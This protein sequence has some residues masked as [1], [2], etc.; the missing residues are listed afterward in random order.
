V[1]DR[2]E[3][4]VTGMLALAIEDLTVTPVTVVLDG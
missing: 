1:R 3:S 2:Y 4:L